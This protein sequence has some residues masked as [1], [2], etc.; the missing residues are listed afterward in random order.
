MDLWGRAW[1]APTDGSCRKTSTPIQFLLMLA[2]LSASSSENADRQ[3]DREGRIP[4]S[5]MSSFFVGGE[6]R[7][8]MDSRQP[9]PC[10]VL[11]VDGGRMGPP[12]LARKSPLCPSFHHGDRCEPSFVFVLLIVETEG[13]FLKGG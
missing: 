2:S 9:V 3:T 5:Q 12:R 6:G 10:L 4:P 13:L 7:E 11:E 1:E 8:D